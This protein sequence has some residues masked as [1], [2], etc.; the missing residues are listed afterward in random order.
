MRCD[1]TSSEGLGQIVIKT[2]SPLFENRVARS[3]LARSLVGEH[4]KYL[5]LPAVPWK[6]LE[7][8]F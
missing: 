7:K 2:G 4:A 1:D 8:W 6:Q 3:R 5:L